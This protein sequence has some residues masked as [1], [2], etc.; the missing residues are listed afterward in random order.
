MK[1]QMKFAAAAAALVAFSASPALADQVTSD[2][3]ASM[4]NGTVQTDRNNLKTDPL[5]HSG[6]GA[7]LK[8][9][10]R[11]DQTAEVP[12]GSDD[13]TDGDI[14]RDPHQGS[15]ESPINELD[16]PDNN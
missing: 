16:R 4:G 5:V 11:A 14:D 7:M 9:T 15:Y 1:R 13:V 8:D 2:G 10:G 6:S 12:Y 3:S